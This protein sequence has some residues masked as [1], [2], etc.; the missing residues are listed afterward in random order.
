M[1][2]FIDVFVSVCQYLLIY[3]LFHYIIPKTQDSVRHSRHFSHNY[4]FEILIT[5]HKI[6]YFSYYCTLIC[7]NLKV[8][9]LTVIEYH[10]SPFM[11]M[12]PSQTL[13]YNVVCFACIIPNS[14]DLCSIINGPIVKFLLILFFTFS[15]MLCYMYFGI[16]FHIWWF[17]YYCYVCKWTKQF[18]LKI[19]VGIFA[20]IFASNPNHTFKF[21]HKY[22]GGNI[23]R[24]IE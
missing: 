18:F 22:C 17:C 6:F 23:H 5:Y 3:S 14:I 12:N 19:K 16:Y 7:I 11:L 2:I 15:Y 10:T 1:L 8:C 9:L 21:F 13:L 20:L 24:I 4:L